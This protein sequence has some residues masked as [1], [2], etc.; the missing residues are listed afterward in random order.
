M[1]GTEDIIRLMYMLLRTPLRLPEELAWAKVQG[2]GVQ[3]LNT[4]LHSKH[5]AYAVDYLSYDSSLWSLELCLNTKLNPN[6]NGTIANGGNPII[7]ITNGT[8]PILYY[9]FPTATSRPIIV[10]VVPPVYMF[11]TATYGTLGYDFVVNIPTAMG[12]AIDN[13]QLLALL[14]RYKLAGKTYLIQLT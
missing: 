1:I 10:T 3:Q 5:E 7:T 13:P 6:F 9:A 14:N 8:R 11:P 4:T 2:Y 12:V